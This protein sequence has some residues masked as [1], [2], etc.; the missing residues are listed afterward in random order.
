MEN[1]LDKSLTRY[2]NRLRKLGEMRAR[3][4][5]LRKSRANFREVVGKAKSDC[6]EKERKIGE[7]ISGSNKAYSLRDGFK[8][9]LVQMK[10]AEKEAI[11]QDEER[12]MRLRERVGAM[13]MTKG[14]PKP[15]SDPILAQASQIG[16]SSDQQEEITVLTESYHTS[17]VQTLDLLHFT[18]VDDLIAHAR[19]LERENFSLYNFVVENGVIRT[20][21]Q[22]ELESLREKKAELDDMCN[23][24][25]SEQSARL[26]E[27]TEKLNATSGE[28]AA[29]KT[30]LES[31]QKEFQEIYTKLEDLFNLLGCSWEG[32]PDMKE[33]ISDLNTM[34][35]L[36]L[37]ENSLTGIMKEVFEQASIQYTETGQ[38]V[39]LPA[40]EGGLE[41]AGSAG[42]GGHLRLTIEREVAGKTPDS[43]RPLT[44]EELRELL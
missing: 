27:L 41:G 25:E 4:D 29:G 1:R 38:D 14:H 22:E 40:S 23:L 6:A 7:L 26:S 15:P 16:S 12:I 17:T 33:V 21:L 8:M 37:I 18:D 42:K 19:E 34:W 44:L 13:K 30:R 36:G 9:Q 28:L 3:I 24:T 31:E 2:N 35:C 11:R 10:A 5:E 39:K 32:S 43:T 20:E